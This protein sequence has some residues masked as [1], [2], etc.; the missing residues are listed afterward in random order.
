[1]PSGSIIELSCNPTNT[2][3]DM[4][5]QI[6]TKEGI[7]VREHRLRYKDVDL[8]DNNKYCLGDYGIKMN[9]TLNV[10]LKNNNSQRLMQMYV[11]IF[12][13]YYIYI[14]N[15]KQNDT[16]LYTHNENITHC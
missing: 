13:I 7:S 10:V 15:M 8:I 12:Y 4:K 1:M 11:M 3:L 14:Y 16:T 9:D 5:K 2:I 6:C